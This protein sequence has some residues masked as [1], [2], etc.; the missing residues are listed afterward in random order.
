MLLGV[1]LLLAGA[2]AGDELPPTMSVAIP[3]RDSWSQMLAREAAEQSSR[4][5]PNRLVEVPLLAPHANRLPRRRAQSRDSTPGPASGSPRSLAPP[6]HSVGTSFPAISLRDQFNAFG[7]GS[8]PPDTMGA[9]GPDHFLQ[10]IN[11][12]VAVFDRTGRRLSHVALDTFFHF[13]ENGVTYPRNGAFDPRVLYDR[14]SGR[15]I[16]SALERGATS[17]SANDAVLAISATGDPLGAWF[18]YLVPI[19]VPTD[20][21]SYFSDFDTLGTDDNGV[22]VL[23]SIFPSAGADFAKLV[24]LDKAPLLAGA[25]AAQFQF[26]PIADVYS[27]PQPA[28]NLDPVAADAPAWFVA[29]WPFTLNSTDSANLSCFTLTWR[30]A[31]GARTPT[32]G[33]TKTVFTATFGFPAEAP[34]KGATVKLDATDFRLVN[35]L[36]RNQ[37]L[38]TCRN[39]GVNDSG[40]ASGANRTGCEWLEL[41]LA[42]G[43]A[44]LRQSG[45][46]FDEAVTD[47]HFFLFPTIAVN[48]QGH[49]VMAFTSTSAADFP[50]IAFASRLATDPLGTMRDVALIKSGEHAYQRLDGLGRNRWGDYSFTSVDPRDDL[51]LWTVQE[52]AKADGTEASIWGTWVARLLAPPPTAASPGAVARRGM[53]GVFL[54]I[55]GSGFFDPGPGFSNRFRINLTGGS[56]NGLGNFRVTGVTPNV[57]QVFLDV[58]EDAAPG[59]RELVVTNPDG[60]QVIVPNAFRIEGPTGTT[61]SFAVAAQTVNESGGRVPVVVRLSAPPPADVTVP[62]TI[63]GSAVAG[64]DFNLTPERLVVAAGATSA[65][66]FV[67][68]LNDALAETNKT[69]VLTLGASPQIGLGAIATHTLTLLDDDV[70]PV[71][72]LAAGPVLFIENAAPLILDAA[73][74]VAA[75]AAGGAILVVDFATNGT[76]ADR[77]ALSLAALNAGGITVAGEQLFLGAQLLGAFSGGR[78]NPLLRV[79]FQATATAAAVQAVVRGVTFENSSDTPASVPRTVRLRLTDGAG[80][81]SAPALK[82]VQVQAV[83]DAP[84]NQTTPGI[85]GRARVGQTLRADP[86]AWFDPD[87][88]ALTFTYLW[89]R[90]SRADGTAATGITTTAAYLLAAADAHQFLRLVVTAADPA[91]ARQ[92][93]ASAWTPVANTPPALLVGGGKMFSNPRSFGSVA[94]PQALATADLDGDGIPDLVVANY[95]GNTVG[96]LLGNGDGT[97]RQLAERATGLRPSGIV[98]ADLNH[99]GRPD[100]VTANFSAGTV[101]VFLGSSGGGF[102]PRVDFPAGRGTAWV[103]AADL[104][105]DGIPDLVTANY[106]EDTVAILRGRG[107]GTFLPRQT[108]PTARGP[109]CVTAGDFNGDGRLDL[110][111]ANQETSFVSVFSNRGGAA[112]GPR[113]DFPTGS[114]PRCLAV[115]DLNGDGLADLVVTAGTGAAVCVLLG[116]PNGNFQPFVSYPTAANPRGLVLGD[117]NSDGRLDLAVAN[118]GGDSASLLFGNGDGTFQTRLDFPIGANPRALVAADFNHDGTLDLLAGNFRGSQLTLL[119]GANR[120]G[121]ALAGAFTAG[122]PVFT[123]TGAW[124]DAD[125]DRINFTFQWQRSLDARDGTATPI[126]GATAASYVPVAADANLFLRAVITAGDTAGGSGTARTEWRQLRSF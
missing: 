121:P 24:A 57:A 68:V 86:G 94:G 114:S 100:L 56:P 28:L 32:L 119:P 2:R 112:F 59:P 98:I 5:G 39:V 70:A 104:N 102:L 54:T 15:W 126:P 18:H 122:Q 49:A 53:Q 51:S 105:G 40:G 60:Q 45:R 8:V 62:F 71:I 25:P 66:L 81:R 76:P 69:L 106:S 16:A 3:V 61:I 38:W 67:N 43:E 46:V 79:Q 73:A 117:F 89:Q 12:S 80:N 123:T 11:S 64:S 65:T 9:I 113:V 118:S 93:A 95:N 52:Y 58:A 97:F 108:L 4:V 111:V 107:D 77:L 120:T 50:G 21:R 109:A 110:A 55:S 10:V 27:T 17:E 74:L 101:S 22:Y 83:N 91:G 13:T 87:Q 33:A 48:G 92:T 63:S 31:P 42:G 23:A 44:R 99:D 125:G 14:R 26:A 1:G 36:L 35:A 115:A 90:A 19:S 103:L 116:K 47:P 29:S 96:I 41:D 7:G 84:T 78:D 85:L 75:P 88:D 82:I 72:T 34:A 124:S 37:R 30:G 20:S 6:V